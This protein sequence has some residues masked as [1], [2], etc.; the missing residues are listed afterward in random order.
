MSSSA[1]PLPSAPAPDVLTRDILSTVSAGYPGGF[2]ARLWTGEQWESGPRPAAFTLALKHPGALRAMLWPKDKLGLGESYVFDDFDIEGDVLAFAGWMGYVF[3]QAVKRRGYDNLKIAWNLAALPDRRNPRDP[4]RSARPTEGN[5]QGDRERESISYSY[6]LPGEFYRL[7]L[8]ANMQYSC[9]YFASPDQDL[10]AAQSGKLDHICRKL[11]L[12]PGERL[13]DVGCG[14]GGLIVHAAKHYG[15]EAV[16]ITLAA[17]QAAWARRAIEAA[18]VGDRVKVVLSDYRDFRDADGFDKAVSV[19]MGEHVR[20]ENLL[21]YMAAV[22]DALKPGGTFLY[23]VITLRANSAFPIWTEFSGKY[24]FPN[25]RLH[26]LAEGL[27]VGGAAGFEVRDVENL[28]EHYSLTLRNWVRRLDARRAEALGMTDEVNYRIYRLYMA[29]ATIGFDSGVY[30]LMQTLF[31][32]PAD[33]DRAGLPLT[34]A[35]WYA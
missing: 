3:D 19:G 33:G 30:E 32:N 15:V 24:V 21:G 20:P 11:R 17:E 29:G 13:L 23:H 2:A 8:D 6:D 22:H 7:F 14:W 27:R 10:D 4:A 31:A 12:K 9:G 1:H 35:D 16:G 28:R 5:H 26:T 18:G 34:R 25:G